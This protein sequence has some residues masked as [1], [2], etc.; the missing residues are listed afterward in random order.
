MNIDGTSPGIFSTL[1]L[2][3]ESQRMQREDTYRVLLSTNNEGGDGNA[4]SDENK[5]EPT[6]NKAEEPV[7]QQEPP[8]IEEPPASR[9][10]T[11]DEFARFKDSSRPPDSHY[12]PGPGPGYRRSRSA[13]SSRCNHLL[14]Y[15]SLFFIFIFFR[16]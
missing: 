16:L 7:Q 13:E 11:Y 1:D 4:T 15:C 6:E 3:T 8:P 12:P 14:V 9:I 2:P 5:A 10:P